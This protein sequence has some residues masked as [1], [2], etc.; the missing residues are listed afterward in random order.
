ME[1]AILICLNVFLI[2]VIGSVNVDSKFFIEGIYVVPLAPAASTMSGATFQPF[3]VMLFI[4]GWYFLIFLSKV[5]VAN[6]S[7]QYV[8][9]MNCMVISGV[10]VSGGGWL[11]GWPRMHSMSGLSLALQWHLWESHVHGSSHGGTVFSCG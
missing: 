10:G 6:L 11:Y 7:L 8:N 4:S 2:F 9:S 1:C 5:L 3:V